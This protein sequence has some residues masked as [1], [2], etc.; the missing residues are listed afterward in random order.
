MGPTAPKQ[1]QRVLKKL[2]AA[3]IWGAGAI[4]RSDERVSGLLR[5]AL[6][7][8]DIALVMF[9]L[10]G[11]LS[12]IPALR[13]VFDPLYAEVWSAALGAAALGCLIG[14]AFPAHLWK[15]ER[16][17]KAVLASMLTVYGGA[18]IWAGIITDDLGRS[19][20][21][22][23]PVALVPVLAWRILDVTKDAQRNGWR[24]APR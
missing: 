1:K 15:V 5:V 18:L 9:G 10:G 22:F 3:S 4:G 11:F 14:L 16:S 2:R 24:G 23:I 19:A 6:P 13:D 7:T 20:V 17:G 12:G 8:V 21:G